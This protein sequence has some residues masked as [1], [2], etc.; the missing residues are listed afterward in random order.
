MK[1]KQVM[2]ATHQSQ[3]GVEVEHVV[4]DGLELDVVDVTDALARAI[5]L[6]AGGRIADGDERRGHGLLEHDRGS[7]AAARQFQLGWGGEGRQRS[8]R[9][10]YR[11]HWSLPSRGTLGMV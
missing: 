6:R 3:F 10:E 7:R 8:G 11:F 1:S 2:Q 5:D 9:E 4:A